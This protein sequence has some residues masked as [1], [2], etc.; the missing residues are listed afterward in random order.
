MAKS[1]V[2]QVV[3]AKEAR[4]HGVILTVGYECMAAPRKSVVTGP[5]G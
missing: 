4:R 5:L 1:G 2:C 3:S